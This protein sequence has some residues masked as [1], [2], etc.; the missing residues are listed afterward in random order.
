MPGSKT[1]IILVILI[2]LVASDAY[3]TEMTFHGKVIDADT[4]QPI[5]GALVIAVWDEE[6]ATLAGIDTRFK[7]AKEALTNQTGDWSVIGPK[8]KANH[9]NP[10]TSLLFGKYYLRDPYFLIYKPG[11]AKF[12]AA[13]G[14]MAYPYADEALKLKG[15]ILIRPGDTW[16]EVKQ[17]NKKYDS[18]G[19]IPF[20]HAREPERKLRDLDFSFQYPENTRKI[21]SS[22]WRRGIRSFWVYTVV[23]IKKATTEEERLEAIPYLPLN[24]K[25]ELPHFFKMR[26]EEQEN[27]KKFMGVRQ[28]EN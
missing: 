11:Y 14:F 7:D 20:V 3:A 6:R 4:L 27:F 2:S 26:N 25:K 10:Y 28:N 24:C 1:A 5:E 18:G 16:E 23:G 22:I 12:G 9:M 8:G 19:F 21:G 17:F 13:G 15:I